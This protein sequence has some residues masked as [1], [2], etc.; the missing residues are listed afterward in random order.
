MKTLRLD[1]PLPPQGRPSDERVAETYARL[2]NVWK[3]GI[4]LGV[5]GQTV[6]KRLKKMGVECT[7]LNF[8]S[9]GDKAR[10][11]QYYAETDAKD[12]WLPDLCAELG[13]SKITIC[14]YARSLGLTASG[15][16]DDRHAQGATISRMSDVPP[17]I[18]RV[19]VYE[20][21]ARAA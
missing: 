6:H 17:G 8:L 14:K 11:A 5:S 15:I 20:T 7:G 18:C 19:T 13:R 3:A 1:I 10:I 4:V 9:E 21:P 16:S 12:F 2:G